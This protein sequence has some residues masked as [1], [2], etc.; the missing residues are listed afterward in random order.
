MLPAVAPEA[1]VN[2]PANSGGHRDLW[3]ACKARTE[4][5]PR[6]AQVPMLLASGEA[7]WTWPDLPTHVGT[8]GY[9]HLAGLT[10]GTTYHRG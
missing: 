9:R 7:V 6:H 1:Y 2:S 10:L 8:L 5:L 3:E 4:C